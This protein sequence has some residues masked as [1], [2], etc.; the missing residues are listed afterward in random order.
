MLKVEKGRG[1][2][3]NQLTFQ[4]TNEE[5]RWMQSI[6]DTKGVTLSELIRTTVLEALE[7]QHDLMLYEDAM[8]AHQLKDESISHEEMIREMKW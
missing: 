8:K 1:S 6:A 7:N 4:V 5:K 2:G 3:M